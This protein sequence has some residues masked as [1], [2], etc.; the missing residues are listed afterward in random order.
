MSQSAD[1]AHPT[2]DV[3]DAVNRLRADYDMTPYT[4][5]S[6]PQS[7]PG[8]LAAVAYLFGL[9]TPEVA[10]AR[11]LEI[12]CGAGGNLIPFA[13]AHPRARV[14][15][16]DLSQV[17]IDHGRPRV[18]ALGLDNLRLLAGDI[19]QVTPGARRVSFMWSYPNMMPLPAA[20]VRRV[21]E[22]LAP[23]SYDRIYGAFAGQEVA[24]DGPAIVARSAAR[25][26]EILKEHRAGHTNDP[27]E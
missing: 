23:W 11:V 9:E 25:Y 20:E 1:Q 21:A 5:N 18:H 2:Y 27:A 10:T 8:Q 3:D 4:S 16:I 13:A 15:G 26:A 14:V 7:A 12:G 6:Y 17:Q 22:R 19:V 24:R